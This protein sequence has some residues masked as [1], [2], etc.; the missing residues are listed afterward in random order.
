MNTSVRIVIARRTERDQ[1]A[2]QKLTQRNE[3]YDNLKQ[4]YQ[5]LESQTEELN[6]L[7]LLIPE[8]ETEIF[9]LKRQI[10]SKQILEQSE[11]T[12]L[13]AEYTYTR[14]YLDQLLTVLE[15]DA[16]HLI[17]PQELDQM[18]ECDEATK[19]EEWC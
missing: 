10:K 9:E 17:L 14:G 12:A 6:K 19:D 18:Q 16:P 2:Q 4:K 8:M 13:E 7:K 1:L 11:F 3:S 15:R 5:T